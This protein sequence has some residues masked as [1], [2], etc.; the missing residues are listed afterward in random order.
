VDPAGRER[1]I[2]GMR[3]LA[4]GVSVVTSASADGAPCGIT[5]TSVCSVSADP[6][7][8]LACINVQNWL[9]E[10]IRDTERMAVNVL[11]AGQQEVAEVFAAMK[12]LEGADRFQKGDWTVLQTG[13]PV[14]KGALAAF[15]CRVTEIVPFATHL[16]VIGEVVAVETGPAQPRLLY[17]GGDFTS[18]PAG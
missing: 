7:S 3:E 4:S 18:L 8:L 13:A 15:D 2:A 16:V 10:V 1:F 5:A 9:A 11:A 14:L 6:P 12:G 17:A